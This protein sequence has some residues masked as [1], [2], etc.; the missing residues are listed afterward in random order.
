MFGNSI[1]RRRTLM[2]RAFFLGMLDLLPIRPNLVHVFDFRCAEYMRMA[3]YQFL[4]QQSTDSLKIKRA[5][6]SSHLTVKHHLQQQVSQ[7]LGHFV[8]VTGLNGVNQFIHFLDGMPSQGH[9]V[10]L[11]VPW[12]ALG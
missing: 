5:S 9:V 6:L 1:E 11:A 7:F 2:P 10:L 8:V 4:H 12:A 3:A